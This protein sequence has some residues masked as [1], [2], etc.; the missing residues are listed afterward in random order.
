MGQVRRGGLKERQVP[1]GH[2]RSNPTDT[3]Y[4]KGGAL[5]RLPDTR[6]DILMKVGAKGLH[7]PNCGCAFPFSQGRWSYSSR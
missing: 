3:F 2:P 4:P 7:Q 1:S 6:E 5:R